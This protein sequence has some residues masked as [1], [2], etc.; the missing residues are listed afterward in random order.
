MLNNLSIPS[1]IVAPASTRFSSVTTLT[2]VTARPT[3]P[4]MTKA[5]ECD[6][7]WHASVSKDE[8]TCPE[9]NKAF[10]I[11]GNNVEQR[12]HPFIIVH[13]EG[14]VITTT[15]KT[16]SNCRIYSNPLHT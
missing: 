3:T 4:C 13:T 16:S 9:K 8:P 6:D 12:G 5:G 14:R 10:N 7:T 2:L 15:N 11:I 1:I